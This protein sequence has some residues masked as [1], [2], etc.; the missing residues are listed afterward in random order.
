MSAFSD[1]IIRM[2]EYVEEEHLRKFAEF[3]ELNSL[4]V[5]FTSN[6]I[7]RDSMAIDKPELLVANAF[8]WT[9]SPEGYKYWELIESK[10]LNYLNT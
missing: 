1:Y 6:L 10:W 3:L 5:P 2:K 9:N 7:I 8:G 4:L